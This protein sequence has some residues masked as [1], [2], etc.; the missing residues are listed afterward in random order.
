MALNVIVNIIISAF[1]V[2]GV[3][4][5]IKRG[6]IS[7]AAKPVKFFAALVIAFSFASA[8]GAAVINPIIEA[9]ITNYIKDFLYTNC[10][11]LTSSNAREELPTILKISAAIFGID[12]G[13]VASNA[14]NVL[15]AI[16]E[17]LTAPVISVVSV[18]VAFIILYFISKV[19]LSVALWFVNLVFQS[20][21]FGFL[22][23]L[24]GTVFGLCL[25]VIVSWA[26]VAVFEYAVHLPM[27]AANPTVAEFEGT[28]IYGFFNSYSPMELLLSF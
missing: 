17:S 9:P 7:L 28:F 19:L 4:I 10:E 27:F 22:N 14:T 26:F 24:L 18:I 6:F 16:V 20:G 8:F 13:E 3:I 5:G 11:G 25:A 12:I 1:F 2:A 23:K 21:V 15:D